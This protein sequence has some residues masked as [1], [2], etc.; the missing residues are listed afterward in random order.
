M[1]GGEVK[2][3]GK[4][5]QISL[6]DLAQQS[7]PFYVSAGKD[8]ILTNQR[9]LHRH[10]GRLALVEQGT[11]LAAGQGITEWSLELMQRMVYGGGGGRAGH[12][13]V[14]LGADAEGGIGGWRRQGRAYK[15]GS[16]EEGGGGRAGHT[17]VDLRGDGED[18]LADNKEEEGQPRHQQGEGPGPGDQGLL[19][20][21]EGEVEA[22]RHQQRA[23]KRA[24]AA[25]QRHDVPQKPKSLQRAKKVQSVQNADAAR[26]LTHCEVQD[27]GLSQP[28]LV[29]SKGSAKK[30]EDVNF[31]DPPTPAALPSA[32]PPSSLKLAFCHLFWCSRPPFLAIHTLNL[33]LA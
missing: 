7:S 19:A 3:G 22:S 21:R 16:E 29:R 2:D 28:T 26:D 6:L 5:I 1:R 20:P 33:L 12:T 18:A 17:R 23:G 8:S 31:R 4:N 24:E 25:H 13:R 9:Q 27:L 15:S 10:E 32:F 11:G 30:H 14:E